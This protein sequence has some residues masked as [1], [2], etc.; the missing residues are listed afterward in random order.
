MAGGRKQE[1]F[2]LIARALGKGGLRGTEDYRGG[3]GLGFW[4]SL[5]ISNPRTIRAVEACER[6]KSQH[7]LVEIYATCKLALLRIDPG[8]GSPPANCQIS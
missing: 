2:R 8:G 7:I 3:I 5:K 6:A 4:V 1:A